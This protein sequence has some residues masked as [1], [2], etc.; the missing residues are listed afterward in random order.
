MAKKAIR[1]A[2]TPRT[3]WDNNHPLKVAELIEILKNFD[4]DLPIYIEMA[5]GNGNVSRSC[6]Y[7]IADDDESVFFANFRSDF[8]F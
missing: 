1:M 3:E 7:A 5:D 2:K 8:G 6:Q 4:Q